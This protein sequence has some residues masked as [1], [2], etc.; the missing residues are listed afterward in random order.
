MLPPAGP[1][2]ETRPVVQDESDGRRYLAF[3][4]RAGLWE[5]TRS[6]PAPQRCLHE[7]VPGGCAQRLKLDV[8]V[9]A[10]KLDAISLDTLRACLGD[11]RVALLT[12][13]R[14]DP[15]IESFIDELLG[16]AEAPAAAEPPAAALHRERAQ[17]MEAIL[18]Y[19]LDRLIDELYLTYYAIEDISTTRQDLIVAESSG[20]TSDGWKFSYHVIVAPYAVADNEE[21]QGFTQS[22]LEGLPGESRGCSIGA[23]TSGCRTSAWL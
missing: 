9:P 22:F 12:A 13:G 23:S 1:V 11:E 19:A 14:P 18:G 8:D 21:A 3:E 20:L 15:G 17:K 5:Y 4:S 16:P 10:H 6:L 7:V 2:S